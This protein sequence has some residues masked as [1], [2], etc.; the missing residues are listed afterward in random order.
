MDNIVTEKEYP[1]TGIA[2]SCFSPFTGKIKV[3]SYTNVPSNSVSE[4]K[5]A[6][7]K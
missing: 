2:D 7:A 3:L 5:A 1:Y 6:I 4:L